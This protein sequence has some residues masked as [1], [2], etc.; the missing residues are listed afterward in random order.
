LNV[1]I[2]RARYRSPSSLPIDAIPSAISAKYENLI[3]NINLHSLSK[4]LVLFCERIRESLNLENSLILWKKDDTRSSSLFF[5]FLKYVYRKETFHVEEFRAIAE[6]L[7]ISDIQGI[8]NRCSKRYCAYL[9]PS[10]IAR[11]FLFGFEFFLDSQINR[12]LSV[13]FELSIVQIQKVTERNS[14]F[15]AYEDLVTLFCCDSFGDPV[16]LRVLLYFI[17]QEFPPVHRCIFWQE[18]GPLIAS[19]SSN[20]I[21]PPPLDKEGFLY[22]KEVSSQVINILRSVVNDYHGNDSFLLELARYHSS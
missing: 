18:V 10:D 6:F 1:S 5:S 7:L 21:D 2:S 20:V 16:F 3:E 14:F 13:L 8:L 9:D 4:N 12:C 19:M 11:L 22:P 15:D 17:R